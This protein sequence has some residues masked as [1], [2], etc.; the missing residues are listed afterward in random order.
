M[1][2]SDVLSNVNITPDEVTE[3]SGKIVSFLD[4]IVSKNSNV[5]VRLGWGMFKSFL[6]ST[7]FANDIVQEVA[8]LKAAAPT[9]P[10]K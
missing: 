9:V 3:A 6:T 5:L 4:P 7:A 1:Q 2:L 10:A 8:S